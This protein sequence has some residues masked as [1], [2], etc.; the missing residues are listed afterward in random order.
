[1]KVLILGSN[2][3]LPVNGRHPSSQVLYVDETP[4]LIDCGEGTQMLMEKYKVRKSKIDHIFISHLHGDHVFG[5]PGLLTSYILLGRKDPLFIFGPPDTKRFIESVFS[6]TH[7]KLTYELHITEVDNLSHKLIFENEHI[8]VHSIPLN[9]RVPTSGYKFTRKKGLRKI[10]SEAISLYNLNVDQIKAAKSGDDV[11]SGGITIPNDK[12]TY[13]EPYEYSYAYCSDTKYAPEIVP[14]ITGVDLLYHESTYLSD[15]EIQAAERYHS[16]ARQAA[17][18]AREARA[19][20]LLIG[21]FSS[22]YNDLN[23]FLEEAST[24]FSNVQIARE[25]NFY[26]IEKKTLLQ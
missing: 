1:M 16:T 23:A 13:G 7:A 21:H 8:I 18:I 14:F 9:H 25:G 12:V 20:Q 2:S 11:V 26:N 17:D 22:R 4:Y 15:L 5:L 24:G 10:R 19:G 3:A 6:F